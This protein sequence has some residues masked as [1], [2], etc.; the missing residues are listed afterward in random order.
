MMKKLNVDSPVELLGLRKSTPTT[1]D[2][3]GQERGRCLL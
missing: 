3:C 1:R 2:P